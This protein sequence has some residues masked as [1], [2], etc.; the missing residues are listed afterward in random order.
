MTA[1]IKEQILPSYRALHDFLEHE[2]LPRARTSVGLSALPLGDA[3]YAYLVKRTTGGTLTPAQLHALGLAEVAR[4]HQ[5]LEALLGQSGYPGNAPGF[6][7]HLRHDLQFSYGTSADLTSAYE[8]L[9]AQVAAAAP[10]LFSDFPRADFEIRSVEPFRQAVAAP[11]SYAPRAPNGLVAAAL[12]V[13]TAGLDV[14]PAIDTAAQYLREAVPGHHYQLELQ[15]ELA[16]LPRFRRFET[17]PAFVEGW[18]LYAATL[19]EELR[20]YDSA[21]ARFGA[22]RAELHCAAQL[23][24]DTGVHALGW[25]R[26]QALDYMIAAL[27]GDDNDAVETVDRMLALPAEALA[28]TVGLREIQAL[29]AAAQQVLGSRVDLRA[30]HGAMVRGGAIPLDMLEARIKAWEQSS[31]AAGP[32]DATGVAA[33]P[34]TDPTGAADGAAAGAPATT[35]AASAAPASV[36]ATVAAP[37][38]SPAPAA[39]PVNLAAPGTGPAP[40]AFPATVAAPGTRPAPASVPATVVGP[41]TQPAPAVAPAAAPAAVPAT[42]AAPASPG[43]SSVK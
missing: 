39:L 28:C 25:T 2:Y 20:L 31:M 24:I 3:W 37:E 27:P 18:G 30:F 5:R 36:P 10:A 41:G 8:A 38:T 43:A 9:K 34:G 35:P 22:L 1:V 33:P 23:V 4:L 42:T 6:I 29:K 7:E 40:A 14:R 13:N 12:Y 26:Q 21:E 15:H 17:A 16:D 19:G 11:L 32:A